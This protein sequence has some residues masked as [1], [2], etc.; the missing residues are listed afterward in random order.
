[1][2]GGPENGDRKGPAAKTMRGE[3]RVITALFCDVVNS[4]GLAETMD[5]EDW[6]DIMNRA[7]EHLN[8]PIQHYGGTVAKLLG[9]A[10]LAFFGA[11]VA[12]EDDPRRA[13]LAALGMVE[14]IKGFAA[15]LK[16]QHGID[17]D[18]RVGINT[19]PVVVGDV[20]SSGANE[21]TAMGD[22]MNIAARMEQTALPG[23]VQISEDTCR[24]VAPWCQVEALGGIELKGKS[25][26]VS[27]YRVLSEKPGARSLQRVE[28]VGAPLIGRDA[29]LALLKKA[30]ADLQR[31]RGG[32]VCIVG[33]AGLGKSRLLAELH[34]AWEAAGRPG[35]W[36]VTHGIPYDSSRPYGLFQ[37][38]ARDLFGIEFDDPADVVHDKLDRGLRA[39][40][41]DNEDAVALCSVAM[42]RLIAA[43]VL[44]E[45]KE[46]SAEAIRE[47]IY[48][49]MYP[50]LRQSTANG[51]LVMVGDDLHWADPASV[52]LL[53]HLLKLSEEVPILFVFAF[54][55]ERQSPAWL[56][57]QKADAE[58][59][60]RYTE[61]VLEPLNA[62]DTDL[63][64]SAL[65]D[66]SD[67][68]AELRQL[69]IRK[70]DGNPY[71]VEEIIRTLVEQGHVMR[72]ADGLRWKADSTLDQVALP[73]SLQALLM[74]RIDRLDEQTKSTLQ[75]ASVIGRSFYY[76]ILETISDEAISLDKQLG[77]LE[78][79]ELLRE[80]GR[81]PEL[82]YIFKHDLARDAA[83]GSILNRKRREVHRRV[84]E[85]I[86]SLF[87]ERLEEHA[88][89]IAQHFALAGDD[90]K[91]MKYFAMAG[92]AAAGLHASAEGAT[93][94]AGAVEAARRL[95]V[96]AEEMARLE[97][98]RSELRGRAV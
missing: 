19:G 94:Y 43:K 95:G 64:V 56:L 47:D 10:V 98:K 97:A 21:Y 62:A 42:E 37:N 53:V 89:R 78:R 92:E 87:P 1:M 17:F 93:H 49:N 12:H 54:R 77:S 15:E 18:V 91:A 81:T 23:T 63:L 28:T 46:F 96:S 22:A 68:P 83:Y 76:R 2:T 72:T 57:K 31:G 14:A 29:Q 65:L 9:D 13:V 5:P 36:D 88:H 11:P 30:L 48:N 34:N 41:G 84:A 24:L 26:P 4:T 75:T 59:H 60:N 35:R 79:A 69:I 16:Q 86:E 44:H 33:E 90:A 82:E 45:A 20:G 61:I 66:I 73:D 71:F 6:T 27:V 52:D 67:L 39:Q 50:A 55:P 74:A 70:T 40:L 85:A 80:A 51:P 38:F 32:I 58:Y 8:A 3:R 25:A 7:F